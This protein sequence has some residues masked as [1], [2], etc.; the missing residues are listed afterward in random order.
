MLVSV[1]E[2]KRVGKVDPAVRRQAILDA[3]LDVFAERWFEEARLDDVAAQAGVAK[4]T[5][6]LYFDDKEALFE[7]VVR[8]TAAPIVER[9]TALAA[10]AEVPFKDL[11]EALFK[12]FEKEVLGTRRKLLIRLIIAEGPRFPR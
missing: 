8:S 7:E 12:V 6:Y 5:L 1:R 3:A 9:L 4:G 2:S 10:M 11:L